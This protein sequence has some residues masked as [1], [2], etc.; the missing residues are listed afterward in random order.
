MFF[1]E[2]IYDKNHRLLDPNVCLNFISKIHYSKL[3]ASAIREIS[4]E[5]FKKFSSV[6]DVVVTEPIEDPNHFLCLLKSVNSLRRLSLGN[7]RLS[8]EFYSRLPK[9]AP[10]LIELIIE[11]EGPRTAIMRLMFIGLHICKVCIANRF[12]FRFVVKV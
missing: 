9:I 10:F 7:S 12:G 6:V 8:Q 2:F 3:I 1:D 5:F 11:E 4:K